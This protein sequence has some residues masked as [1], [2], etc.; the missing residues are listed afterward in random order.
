M[1]NLIN[2]LNR[3]ENNNE[4]KE[5]KYLTNG[6]HDNLHQY[7]QIAVSQAYDQLITSEGACNWDNIS[8]LK[9]NGYNVFP[10]DQD[11]FGWLTGCIR[12]KK[13]IIVYG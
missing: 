3:I 9:E 8:T 11:S 5:K 4:I 2:I 12:T 10:G 6:C 13:G 7:I 1:E